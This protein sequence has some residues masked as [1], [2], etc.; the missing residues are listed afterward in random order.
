MLAACGTAG[1]NLSADYCKRLPT[2]SWVTNNQSQAP[3]VPN[4]V[5]A[6]GNAKTDGSVPLPRCASCK[7]ADWNR[8]ERRATA[9]ATAR[10]A[11]A[12]HAAAAAK[13]T[14]TALSRAEASGRG[15]ASRWPAAV[16]ETFVNACTVTSGG[17]VQY[18]ECAADHLAR[19][20]SVSQLPH[21]ELADRRLFA[22]VAA[23]DRF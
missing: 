23:C 3:C 14:L 17:R 2:G 5:D 11:A 12:R 1:T 8:A 22:A 19:T 18:C 4:P 6:T 10:A 13:A 15:G 20:V 9:R 7:L 16:R 21:M